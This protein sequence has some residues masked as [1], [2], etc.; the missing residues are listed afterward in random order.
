MEQTGWRLL[1]KRWFDRTA[2]AA[3]LVITAPV[4]LATAVAIRATMGTPVLFRQVRPGLRGR[5]FE[6]IKFRTMRDGA[7]SDSER[8]TRLGR[9]LRATSLDELPQLINVVRGELSLVGPRPLLMSYLTRYS[10]Q[11]ARRHEVLPGITGWA[12]INGRNAL[13]WPEKLELD[14]WYVEHWN[15]VLDV[16]ILV[17]TAWKVVQRSGIAQQGHAT[18]PEF[19]GEQ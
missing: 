2:A 12:Q 14:R 19:N 4:M 11:Q 1:A 3:G 16:K 10:P 7:G 15:L 9:A 17:S 18:M 13:S 8:L 5:P 6:L